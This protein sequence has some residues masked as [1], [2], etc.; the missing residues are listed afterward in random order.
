MR[1][2]L[3]V[4]PVVAVLAAGC[5]APPDVM[6]G[7]VVTYAPADNVVVVRDER[8]PNPDV[9]FS[10]EG[11]DIGAVPAPGDE[12]RLAYRRRGATFRAIRVMNLTRQ[13]ELSGKASPGA[14]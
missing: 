8:A 7:R 12:V 14:H 1:R 10:L 13:A 11:S 4:I 2:L 9:A 6:Q 5:G 3:C